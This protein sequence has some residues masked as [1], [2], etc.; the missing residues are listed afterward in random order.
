ML[1]HKITGYWPRDGK[2][3]EIYV[4]IYRDEKPL[5]RIIIMKNE[6]CFYIDIS[7]TTTEIAQFGETI[8]QLCDIKAKQDKKGWGIR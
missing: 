5:D 1:T 7:I 8:K 6:I 2:P 4:D 3:T